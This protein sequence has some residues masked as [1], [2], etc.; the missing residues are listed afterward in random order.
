MDF[1]YRQ[2][3]I[4]FQPAASALEPDHDPQRPRPQAGA[5]SPRPLPGLVLRGHP[6][7]DRAG[8]H[9]VPALRFQLLRHQRDNL[10]KRHG[11]RSLQYP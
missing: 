2:L 5:A 9:L 1:A 8:C 4:P 6:D 7:R 11:D 3:I 10:R